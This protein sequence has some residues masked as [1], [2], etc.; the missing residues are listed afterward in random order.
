MGI[1]EIRSTKKHHNKSSTTSNGSKVQ[2]EKRS[3][4]LERDMELKWILEAMEVKRKRKIKVVD[5]GG[6]K[7]FSEMG[8]VSLR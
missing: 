1:A 8:F 3:T 4:T 5:K 6:R 2:R 7:S